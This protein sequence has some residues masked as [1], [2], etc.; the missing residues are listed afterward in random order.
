VSGYF[1][2]LST[3]FYAVPPPPE[4]DIIPLLKSLRYEHPK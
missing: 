1:S 3:L 2:A 4:S